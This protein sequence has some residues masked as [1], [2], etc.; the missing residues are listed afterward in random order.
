[1]PMLKEPAA[2]RLGQ[3]LWGISGQILGGISGQILGGI[4]LNLV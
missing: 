2:W 3:I 1:M 4:S